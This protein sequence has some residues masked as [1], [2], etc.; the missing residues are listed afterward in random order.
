VTEVTPNLPHFGSFCKYCFMGT[1]LH[2]ILLGH[3]KELLHRGQYTF[4]LFSFLRFMLLVRDAL[5][6]PLLVDV[7]IGL[8]LVAVVGDLVI[9]PVRYGGARQ[10]L[11][12]L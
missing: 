12:V 1:L 11:P 8:T 10:C 9:H 5:V 6:I 2:S 7:H 4:H 3:P